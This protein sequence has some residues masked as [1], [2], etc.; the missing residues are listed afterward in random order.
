MRLA[1]FALASLVFAATA[2]SQVP[3][4]FEVASVRPGAPPTTLVGTLR[5][6]QAL[7]NGQFNGHARL[8]DLIAWA[9]ALE[10]YQ[11]V[12]GSF[13]ELDEWFVIAAKA[14][15][16]VRRTA[17]GEIGPFNVMLQALLADRFKLKVRWE[18]RPHTVYVLRRL[19]TDRLSPNIKA[20]DVDC[21][22]ESRAAIDPLPRGCGTQM[23][24]TNGH[25]NALVGHMSNFAR[26]L[27]L[28]A[29][30]PI[31]DDT[32]LAGPLE[33][34][35]VFDPASLSQRSAPSPVTAQLPAFSTALRDDLGLH[36]EPEQRGVPVL[37]VEHV[38]SP[39][40]N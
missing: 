13:G 11:R 20:L 10:R 32:G 39:T 35:M 3:Q 21:S 36:M 29:E 25:M 8:R 4:S 17:P 16:T 22:P 23:S 15:G 37:I 5:P 12:E 2:S 18:T 33:L 9:Y 1:A 38:E 24:I 6:I 26:A 30:R 27:S 40:E 14:P 19:N 7:P 34:T 31:V 28:M